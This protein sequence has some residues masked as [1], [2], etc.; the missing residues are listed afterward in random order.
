MSE[1]VLIEPPVSSQL[2]DVRMQI[3]TLRAQ[4]A[5]LRKGGADTAKV[6]GASLMI[7]LLSN[8]V[9]RIEERVALQEKG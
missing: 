1:P 8:K 2:R 6:E 7:G 3:Q 4:I 5:E 9:H